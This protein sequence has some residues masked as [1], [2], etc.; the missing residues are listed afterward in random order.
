LGTGKSDRVVRCGSHGTAWREDDGPLELEGLNFSE[1]PGHKTFA[2]EVIV[3]EVSDGRV[4]V[5][6][7]YG[8]LW[9]VIWSGRV[10]A[11]A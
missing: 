7:V 1:F 8:R 10:T 9:D 4:L 11:L 3:V 5:V 6:R 2:I